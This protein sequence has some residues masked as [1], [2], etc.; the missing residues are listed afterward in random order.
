MVSVHSGM[1]VRVAMSQ[2]IVGQCCNVCGIFFGWPDAITIILSGIVPCPCGS[3]G[4][5]NVTFDISSILDVP[6]SLPRTSAT[7][8]ELDTGL[9]IIENTYSEG[10]CG[11]DA[12]PN[13]TP[14]QIRVS[15][16]PTDDGQ[17][18]NLQVVVGANGFTLAIFASSILVPGTNPLAPIS[19]ADGTCGDP[20]NVIA[21]G[22]T[23]TITL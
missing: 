20:G 9:T 17:H 23:A 19:N 4:S 8:W 2:S 12:T 22:G 3:T 6:I 11:G 18:C 1:G 10:D 7:S 14:V 21:T 5:G 16:S 13:H 15:A